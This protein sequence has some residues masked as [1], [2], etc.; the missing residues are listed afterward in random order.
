MNRVGGRR[1]HNNPQL[2]NVMV[3]VIMRVGG[4]RGME[5]MTPCRTRDDED[6]DEVLGQQ[7]RDTPPPPPILVI[8]CL[9]NLSN[10]IL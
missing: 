9:G 3:M 10:K 2:H 1:F 7:E 4:E 5:M 8:L 6:E